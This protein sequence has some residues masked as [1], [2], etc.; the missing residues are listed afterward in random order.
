MRQNDRTIPPS[1]AP[2]I[3]PSIRPSVR[4]SVRPSLANKPSPC[5]RGTVQS[6]QHTTRCDDMAAAWP[7]RK[8]ANRREIPKRCI[9]RPPSGR[10]LPSKQERKAEERASVITQPGE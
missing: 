7:L 4:P 3:R 2:S 10:W 6:S 8:R 9:D 1:I 5:T